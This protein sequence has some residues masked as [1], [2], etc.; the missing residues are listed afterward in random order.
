M[1]FA[2]ALVASTAF[3]VK[4]NDL[5]ED[6]DGVSSVTLYDDMTWVAEWDDSWDDWCWEW[7]WDECWYG[8]WRHSCEDE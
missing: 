5:Y 2:L 4:V 3:A 8:E 6:L 7:N 1:K